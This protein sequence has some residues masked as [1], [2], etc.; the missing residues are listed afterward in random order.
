MTKKKLLTLSVGICLGFVSGSA[1][2]PLP[3]KPAPAH[4]PGTHEF[5]DLEYVPGGGHARALDL[6]VPEKIT[7]AVPVVVWIHGGAWTGGDKT[8]GGSGVFLVR[9]GYAVACIN[10]RL[11]RNVAF[12]DQIYDCKAAVRWLRA[13]ASE[14]HLDP[15]HIGAWGV[16]AGAHL[17]ALL[18]L[19]G[20]DKTLEGDE[21][22]AS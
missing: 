2:Q 19:T 14:Y 4:V 21:G 12:P 11:G 7:G 9:Q 6:F 20:G 3:A 1:Q 15:D 22:N 8:D 17:A 5:R 10:Y 16:S 13:Q 18:G